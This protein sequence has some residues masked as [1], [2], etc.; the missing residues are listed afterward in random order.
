MSFLWSSLGSHYSAARLRGGLRAAGM[1][2]CA[3]NVRALRG[4]E[5]RGIWVAKTVAIVG[6]ADIVSVAQVVFSLRE[7]LF[8]VWLGVIC[9]RLQATWC[10][11]SGVANRGGGGRSC[12]AQIDTQY[13][14]PK[15]KF[16]HCHGPVLVAKKGGARA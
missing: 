8:G 16:Q 9:H 5:A 3:E 2:W 15:T 1:D 12:R 7:L 14:T 10:Q 13:I 4:G 11:I 6:T